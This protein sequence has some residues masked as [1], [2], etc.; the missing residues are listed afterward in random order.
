MIEPEDVQVMLEDASAQ[1][2]EPDFADRVWADARVIS[3]RR[4]R[5]AVAAGATA[6]VA[7]IAA[8]V[9]AGPQLKQSTQQVAPS[10]NPQP[11]ETISVPP[12]GDID[13]AQYWLGPLAGS[14]PW[15]DGLPTVLGPELGIMDGHIPNL[16]SRPIRQIAVVL[17][18]Q[19]EPGRYHP[20]LRSVGGRWAESTI[21]LVPTKDALGNRVAP[22]STTAVAPSGSM[23]AFAQPGKLVVLDTTNG[24]AENIP[25]PSA[26]INHVA[27]TTT[28]DRVMVTGP[29]AAYRVIVGSVTPGLE[30]VVPVVKPADPEVLTPP[31]SLDGDSAGQMLVSYD[32]NGSGRLVQRPAL[33][34]SRWVGSTFSSGELSARSLIPLQVPKLEN[35]EALAVVETGPQSPRKLLVLPDA[36]K[37]VRLPGRGVLGWYDDHTVLFESR[38]MDSGWILAWNVQNGQLLRVTELQT[39]SYALGPTLVR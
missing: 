20:F 24:H 39:D 13:G 35:A 30:R 27:W 23:V 28:S 26:T 21:D 16:E 22:L 7:L 11:T 1:V 36:L 25:L 37:E 19:I 14:E 4:R 38:T 8:G 9:V 12:S 3:R 29:D 33:P 17:M 31:L 6:V 10:P 2:A 5:L 34:V 15:L 32:A 18:R